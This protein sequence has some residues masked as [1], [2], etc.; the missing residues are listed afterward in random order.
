MFAEDGLVQ[1]HWQNP[2]KP[3]I[4]ELVAQGGPFT[5]MESMNQW[6]VGTHD[7]LG[8]NRPFGWIPMICDSTSEHFVWAAPSA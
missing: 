1:L 4:T 7:R 8:A 3:E 2:A 5:D 6:I